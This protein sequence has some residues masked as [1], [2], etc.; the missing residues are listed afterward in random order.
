MYLSDLFVA[1]NR[2]DK[3]PELIEILQVLPDEWW[4]FRGG[5]NWLKV[6]I[7]QYQ[8]DPQAFFAK[9]SRYA[10]GKDWA[11]GK[12]FDEVLSADV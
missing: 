2:V 1:A 7:V 8:K 5:R 10:S 11:K 9:L 4:E 3:V 6:A 12:P